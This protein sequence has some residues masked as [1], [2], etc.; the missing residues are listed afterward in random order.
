MTRVG[1]DVALLDMEMDDI[2]MNDALIN[3][4]TFFLKKNVLALTER[5][6]NKKLKKSK[7][8]KQSATPQN[9]PKAQIAE[10]KLETQPL[11]LEEKYFN[12]KENL[13]SEAFM[14]KL[15]EFSLTNNTKN[16]N[17]K[18]TI[19][20]LDDLLLISETN[21]ILASVKMFL[22]LQI[23]N[24][25]LSGRVI[26]GSETMQQ[27]DFS[28][29][30]RM[31]HLVF[32]FINNS[33]DQI[34]ISNSIS[35]E[36]M[37]LT[38][39]SKP[40]LVSMSILQTI[41]DTDIEFWNLLRSSH[42]SST[43]N[44]IEILAYSKDII[45]ICQKCI[46]YNNKEKIL[47]PQEICSLYIRLMQHLYHLPPSLDQHFLSS[48]R[49]GEFNNFIRLNSASKIDKHRSTLYYIVYLS[50]RGRF[51]LA[52]QLLLISHISDSIEQKD[53]QTQILYNHALTSLGIS[54]FRDGEFEFSH[55]FLS[56][57]HCMNKSRELLGQNLNNAR[58]RTELRK[59]IDLKVQIPVHME[60]SPNV[61]EFAY[62][63][64]ALFSEFYNYILKLSSKQL[65][66][67]INFENTSQPNHFRHI[68]SKIEKEYIFIGEPEKVIEHVYCLFVAIL[69]HDYPKCSEIIRSQNLHDHVFIKIEYPEDIIEQIEA[70][71]KEMCMI[72]FVVNHQCILKSIKLEELAEDFDVGEYE[73]MMLIGKCIH[74]NIV[75]AY[76][77]MESLQI[78]FTESARDLMNLE[79]RDNI[80]KFNLLC[81]K[82]SAFLSNIE[83][84]TMMVDR[85]NIVE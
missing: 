2:L 21:E 18:S 72:S 71:C 61:A 41:C 39:T 33:E 28:K 17:L 69:N 82:A 57:L 49:I 84:Q 13:T 66:S 62:L 29:V 64:S 42:Q 27:D 83:N 55:Q 6:Q 11:T 24:T 80:K 16:F 1:L 40:L 74:E 5:M 59:L 68:L 4:Q 14:S 38:D 46:D 79:E 20:S 8:K 75:C 58:E 85:N 30:I 19:G 36:E 52:K 25:L 47:I 60:I 56:Q 43:R 7:P 53:I 50:N 78:V 45:L 3:F 44:Y 67:G 22:H 34:K 48:N 12:T 35:R 54:A 9:N 63:I 65:N 37:N 73:I 15:E 77:D 51:Q 10:N 70:K 76:I 32:E 81:E 23:A 31:L 26:S